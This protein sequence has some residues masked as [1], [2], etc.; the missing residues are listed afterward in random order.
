MKQDSRQVF[1][2]GDVHGCYFEFLD[3]LK[4]VH[5][6]KSTHRLI[7]VGDIINRGPESLKM[8]EWVRKEEVEIV[9]GNHEY[10]FVK[11]V[12][13]KRQ[14]G[15][16]LE[17][18]KKDMGSQLQEWIQWIETWPFY[19]DEPDFLVVHGG[20]VPQQTPQQ[21]DPWLLMHIRTWDGK[22]L[23]LNNPNHPP[24]YE[25]YQGEK[26]IVYGHWALQGLNV[27]SNTIGLDSGCSYGKKLSG[28]LL[29][30]KNIVQVSAK[31]NYASFL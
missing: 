16:V 27:R 14:V 22:G 13:E 3:L 11:S 25:L 9:Q 30:E 19:L 29:P 18:L 26:L 17:K 23:D 31:K 10:G 28:L 6:H 7:L 8:L 5:Y 2:I 15:S 4:K 12:K 24:W 1:I 21:T 20:L